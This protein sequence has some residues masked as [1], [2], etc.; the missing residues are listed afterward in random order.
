MRVVAVGGDEVRVHRDGTVDL[1]GRQ[2]QRCA[3]GIWPKGRDPNGMADGRRAFVE[4]TDSRSYVILLGNE[5]PP[6]PEEAS[7]CVDKPC[8][9]PTDHVFVLGDN[10]TASADSRNWGF[11][12]LDHVIG[13]VSD[14]RVPEDLP[15]FQKCLESKTD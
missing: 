2:L 13:R 10:R 7:H 9:V 4:W 15:T 1:R 6:A 8:T 3:M 12:P 14:V 5:P 11:V